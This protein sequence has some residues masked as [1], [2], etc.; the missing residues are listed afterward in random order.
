[1]LK[2]L[3]PPESFIGTTIEGDSDFRFVEYIG[4]G[5]YALVFKGYSE[6]LRQSAAY[7][8]IPCENLA[9]GESWK[10][11]PQ[12][13]NSL[14][15]PAV[16]QC[17]TLL[18][19][20]KDKGLIVLKYD[21]VDGCTL[22]DFIKSHKSQV[23]VPFIKSFLFEMLELFFELQKRGIQHGDF[24]SRNIL[25]A[26][27]SEF[28]RNSTEQFRVTD[29]GTGGL[30]SGAK[31]TDDFEQL[32]RVL[33]QLLSCIDYQKISPEEKYVVNILSDH[34]KD[35]HLIERDCTRDPLARNP[36]MLLERLE[37]IEN[38]YE[39]TQSKNE[40]ASLLTPFDYLSCEQIGQQHSLLHALYSN[41]FLGIAE[42]EG[43]NN[44]V[45][46]GPRGCGK[47]TVFRSLSL[48]QQLQNASDTPP[49]ISQGY[50]GIYYHCNDLYFKFPR[51]S[52]AKRQDAIDIP[53]HY[54]S[55]R[56][57][58][59]ILDVLHKLARIS[60]I[61]AIKEAEVSKA[62]WEQLTLKRP[63]L[64]SADSFESLMTALTKECQEI[65]TKHRTD[66]PIT[67]PLYGPDSLLKICEFLQ[68]VI[69][70]ISGKPFFCFVDDYSM[71]HIS[72]ALQQNLNRLLMQ[73]NE[74]CFFKMA[75]ESPVSYAASDIDGKS[76]VEGREFEILNLGLTYLRENTPR[77]LEFLDDVFVRRFGAVPNYPVTNLTELIGDGEKITSNEMANRIADGVKTEWWGR[78]TFSSMCSGDIHQLITLARKMVSDTGGID[79][80]R[81]MTA[82]PKIPPRAQ[83]KAIRTHAGD[84]LRS[85]ADSG[86]NGEHLRQVVT[87]FGNVASSYLKFKHSKNED[88]RPRHQASRIELR[89][90]PIFEGKAK[91]IYDDLIR[92]SVFIQDPR[93]KSLDGQ[94]V[95]RLFLR[96][97]LVPHF[98]LTF[99][100]RDS[101][102]LGPK[103]FLELIIAPRDFE[104]RK[105]LKSEVPDDYE[106]MK[107]R[108]QTLDLPSRENND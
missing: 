52:A 63:S 106:D 103:D 62:L 37:Q 4:R 28:Q 54:L 50:V 29:F 45:V 75:T 35:K 43:V 81:K 57:L 41:K 49:N 101:L 79:E 68:N 30:T 48:K 27:P 104:S 90:P 69:P 10:L 87:A 70:I 20:S 36:G 107:D 9:P 85:L 95:P 15:N 18:D 22:H 76:Y 47:S 60:A 61:S 56:L 40:S 74:F 83:H 65:V 53:L 99:S 78:E 64:P 94:A 13:A 55:A 105:M 51:Y 25:V 2:Q 80:L 6:T 1:M 77:K 7:K 38:D 100:T 73:R 16:V 91:E 8:V 23:T 39:A 72:E 102:L 26:K 34:F 71:P 88:G 17:R 14:E 97:F 11:E 44:L 98:N 5:S 33:G 96:R 84:F 66:Q 19:W 3:P 32:A 46:T 24:H 86:T 67:K 82:A 93:G 108:Q 89:E 58:Y 21:Y 12:K 59:E 92:Y 31:L 42:I